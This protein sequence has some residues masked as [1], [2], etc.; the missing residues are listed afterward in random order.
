MKIL[1]FYYLY[2]LAIINFDFF[3]EF[4]QDEFDQIDDDIVTLGSNVNFLVFSS[5]S[6]IIK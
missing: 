5:S 1:V 2:Y 6:I 4:E 3:K